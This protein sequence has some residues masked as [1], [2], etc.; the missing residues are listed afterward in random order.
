MTV[1]LMMTSKVPENAIKEAA[2][3]GMQ[4]V[5][6]VLRLLSQTQTHL[7]QQ[8]YPDSSSKPDLKIEA[9]ADVAVNNFKKV[10][11]LLGRTRTGHARFRRAPVAPPS[12]QQAQEPGPSGSLTS[13]NLQSNEQKVSAFKAYQSTPIHRLPPLPHK[14]STKNG[15]LERNDASAAA[16]IKFS[17]SPQISATTSFMSSLTGDTDS[18]H[19][20]M[21]SGFKFANPSN[22]MPPLPCSSMKRKC[23]SMDDGALRCGSASGRCHCSKKR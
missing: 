12:A 11:S 7:G 6:Q 2:A 23:N 20:S 3:A 19:H 22:G 15:F 14:S 13:N 9:V 16:T 21:S 18:K 5:E 10:I 17:N 4:S 1:E 8:Q